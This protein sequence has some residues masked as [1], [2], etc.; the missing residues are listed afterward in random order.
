MN[1]C[2]F[3]QTQSSAQLLH[4][5]NRWVSCEITYVPTLFQILTQYKKHRQ[6]TQNSVTTWY[7]AQKYDHE[8]K[9]HSPK[10]RMSQHEY[11]H[12]SKTE[13]MIIEHE[14]Q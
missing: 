13:S 3:T 7:V 1:R 11:E 2:Y 5:S 9:W 14:R 6:T 10:K 12:E 8:M 4:L